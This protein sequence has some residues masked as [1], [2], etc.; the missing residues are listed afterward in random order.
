MKS[1]R[2]GRRTRRVFRVRERRVSAVSALSAVASTALVRAPR[3][4]CA[5]PANLSSVVDFVAED[6]EPLEVVVHARSAAGERPLVEPLVVAL[7]EF[8]QRSLANLLELPQVV[9]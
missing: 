8:R 4:A 9:R 3:G 1:N 6:V 2:R 7:A 5:Q